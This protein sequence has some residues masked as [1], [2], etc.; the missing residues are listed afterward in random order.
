MVGATTSPKSPVGSYQSMM[1][2]RAGR[3]RWE[4]LRNVSRT[5]AKCKKDAKNQSY[6]SID[7]EKRQRKIILLEKEMLKAVSSSS[8][9]EL[10]A[11]KSRTE[12]D[13][14]ERRRERLTRNIRVKL[15]K[16]V[17]AEHQGEISNVNSDMSSNSKDANPFDKSIA[18]NVHEGHADYNGYGGVDEHN[19]QAEEALSGKGYR[20]HGKGTGNKC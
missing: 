10:S 20:T 2:R 4:V 8:E 11:A 15:Q 18:N 16:C 17:E 12:H 6:L 7:L 1:A 9:A 3:M 13:R 14:A 5:L 19:D